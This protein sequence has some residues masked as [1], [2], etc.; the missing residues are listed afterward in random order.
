MTARVSEVA[1]SAMKR[2]TR[3]AIRVFAASVL[4]CREYCSGPFAMPRPMLP[5]F[6]LDNCSSKL[7][8]E[9]IRAKAACRNDVDSKDFNVTRKPGVF[10]GSPI[11]PDHAQGEGFHATADCSHSSASR[12][13]RRS[14][15]LTW[16]RARISSTCPR[17]RLAC[18]PMQ[19]TRRLTLVTLVPP[20]NSSGLNLDGVLAAARA[21][22]MTV[23][24]KFV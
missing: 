17:Q 1:R 14:P 8:F 7:K 9:S 3:T 22:S 18:T 16:C 23:R 13:Q 6:C 11:G 24:L 12:G 2:C 21:I 5:S 20:L 15:G 4:S 10:L 19:A